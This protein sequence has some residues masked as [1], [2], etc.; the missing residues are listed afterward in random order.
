MRGRLVVPILYARIGN[1][2]LFKSKITFPASL[3]SA[4]PSPDSRFP[5]A[6]PDDIFRVNL[7]VPNRL[8]PTPTSGAAAL[9]TLPCKESGGAKAEVPP[10][11]FH[12]GGTR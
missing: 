5:A 9:T 11:K 7:K 12:K 6:L 2:G 4:E 8:A 10:A 3:Q 1:S